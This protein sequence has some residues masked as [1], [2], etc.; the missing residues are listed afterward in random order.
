MTDPPC[1]LFHAER[2]GALTWIKARTKPAAP[3]RITLP[4]EVVHTIG[5]T[6]VLRAQD[7]KPRK[8]IAAAA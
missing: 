1:A 4:P 2:L 3:R 7:D 6:S 8:A 5:T